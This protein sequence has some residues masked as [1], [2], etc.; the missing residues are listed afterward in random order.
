MRQVRVILLA[1]L[2]TSTAGAAVPP[3]A[4]PDIGGTWQAAFGE[5]TQQTHV[6]WQISRD[7][8]GNW[9]LL[10]YNIERGPE[11]AK[12]TAVTLEGMALKVSVDAIGG[13]YA[14]TLSAD[15]QSLEGTW[16][17]QGVTTQLVLHR[18]TKKTAWKIDPSPHKVRF[19]TVDHDVNLE[20]LD[21]GGK[22]RPIVLL[23]GLGNNA[24]VFD[25]FAPKLTAAHH[26]LAITRRGFGASSAPASG[27][28]ADRL[29]DDVLEVLQAL[30]ISRPIVMG[31]SIAGEELSSIGTRHPELVAGLVY[32]D[33]GFT[34]A[35]YSGGDL[36]YDAEEVRKKL[37]VLQH[38]DGHVAQQLLA[39][40]L[41]RLTKDLQMIP[42][43]GVI[44]DP[45][46][47]AVNGP[48]LPSVAQA[49]FAGEQKYF[50]VSGVPVLAIFADPHYNG[51]LPVPDTPAQAAA[52][53]QDKAMMDSIVTAF[54]Q[55]MPSAHMVRLVHANHYVFRSN[56]A[57][58][59]REVNAF[60]AGI[61]PAP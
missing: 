3:A 49:I 20:V 44:R 6:V 61:P 50:G 28:S 27:Y 48:P 1:L 13:V 29:G 38:G 35:L 5:G 11:P 53:A 22:G 32:L 37:E 30:K 9:Q 25:Q 41:P 54:E 43:D 39:I 19:V 51:P 4:L 14:G 23:T 2:L 52:D 8:T 40:D 15:R 56:E 34:Y 24:H 36:K 46:V 59:L 60:M 31:H 58:V 7:G 16:T 10:G 42:K 18:A 33:A 21:W 45:V 26:V 47:R 17:T 57:D 55:A 12:A